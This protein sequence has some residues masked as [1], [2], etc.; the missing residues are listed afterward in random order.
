VI[1]SRETLDLVA[2]HLESCL[3]NLATTHEDVELGRC[4]R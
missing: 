1:I 4:I 2:P 3:L